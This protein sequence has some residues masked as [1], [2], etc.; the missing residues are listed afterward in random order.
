MTI[1]GIGIDILE[2]KRIKKM[3]HKRINKLSKKIL[4][5]IE[6][7]KF[8]KSKN[9]INFLAKKFTAKEAASKALGTG[10]NKGIYFNNFEIYNNPKG[11]PKIKFLKKSLKLIKK[12]KIKKIHISISDE[13]KYTQSLVIIEKK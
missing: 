2:I 9:K 4:T 11:K 1:L 8:K 12:L 13:K 6:L 3:N 7:K 5:K 10:I